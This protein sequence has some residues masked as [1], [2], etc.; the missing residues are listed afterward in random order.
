[1]RAFRSFPRL[2]GVPAIAF[3][4]LVALCYV[5]RADAYQVGGDFSVQ[6]GSEDTD[7]YI[8]S[9][10]LEIDPPLTNPVG[11]VNVTYTLTDTN[12]DGAT[13]TG[14]GPEG[15]V[16][17]AQYNGWA[18]D[19]F[20]GPQ[21][22]TF[23]ECI[24]SM[25]AGPYETVTA[26]CD[27]PPTLIA[28]SVYDMSWL[29]SFELSANDIVSG[30]GVYAIIGCFG[31]LDDDGRVGLS[32]LAQLL[33]NYGETSGMSHYGGD[34]DGDE[35]VDLADLAALLAVYRTTCD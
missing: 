29:G 28:D 12:G 21:G 33:A 20:G 26:T 24:F 2:P 13:L 18:G 4:L 6:A 7:F 30:A 11:W 14:F 32:D 15:G 22:T 35:D 25:E 34:L 19:P 3:C 31:D 1:M 8:P 16:F 27:V 17:L 23:A 9:G 5:N 10:L